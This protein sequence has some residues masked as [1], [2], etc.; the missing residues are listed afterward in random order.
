MSNKQQEKPASTETA[1]KAGSKASKQSAAPGSVTIT[2]NLSKKSFLLLSVAATLFTASALAIG[3]YNFWLWQ[4]YTPVSTQLT[5][6]Q[7]V[8][9]SRLDGLERQLRWTESALTKE[10]RARKIAESEHEAL[11]TAMKSVSAKLGRTT[12]AWRLAEIEYLL[13][14]ANHR[15][16]LAQDKKTAIAIFETAAKRLRVIGDPSLLNIRQAISDE[17]NVLKSMVDP[18]VTSM[19]LSIGSLITG[20][21]YLPLIDK[22]RLALAINTGNYKKLLSWEE[23]PQAVWED[24]KSLVRVRRH[25]QPIEPLLPPKEAWFLQQNLRLKLE[26][27]R[28]SLLR[29]D[30]RQF[31]QYVGEANSWI[32]SFFDADSPAVRNASI[33]LRALIRVKLQPRTPDVSGS[34]RLLRERLLEQ[35]QLGADTYKPDNSKASQIYKKTS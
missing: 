8:F 27:A 2:K 15:L 30:T 33:T 19:A 7:T 4:K 28:L 10:T 25:Q 16:A 9:G 32:E 14:I 24:I 23:L 5:K 6:N 29:R 18:D 22:E 20:V 1:E 35:K 17:L 21:E 12:I 31:R 3:I 11:S 26:Q 13:T 34:L